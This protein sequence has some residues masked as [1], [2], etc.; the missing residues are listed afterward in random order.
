MSARAALAICLLALALAAA[1]FTGTAAAKV[2]IYSFET[3]V[4]STQA[5]AHA[6][7]AVRFEIG[8]RFT[9]PPVPCEC[10]SV[11]EI[12]A[13]L[14]PGLIAAPRNVPSCTA[15]EFARLKC[16]SDSQVGVSVIRLLGPLGQG[17]QYWFQP[18]Y[19]M[20]PRPG[21]LALQGT[22]TPFV[23]LPVIFTS[24][25]ARTE[26]DY[27][28]EVK[29]Y[30]IPDAATP[31]EVT[32]I[33]WGVPADDRHDV[34]RWPQTAVSTFAY[35]AGCDPE[36]GS[37]LPQLLA[38]EFPD[39]CAV[40][41]TENEED[42][43]P[44]VPLAASTPEVPF[45]A[46]PTACGGPLPVALETVAYD[47]ETDF[48]ETT[49]PAITGCDQLGFD[50]SL[51]AKPTTTAAD[52][53]SG[54]D[55]DLTVPQTLSPSTPSPSAIRAVTVELPEGFT[56]N[57]NAAE[58]K[59]SCTDQQ[60]RFGSRSPAQCPEFAKVGTLGVTSASFPAVLPGAIYLGEP[61]PG[62]RYRL[63][64]VFD[65]FSLHVKLPGVATPDPRTGRLRATFDNL[66]Q[67]NFQL[68]DMHFF[69]AERG[70][71]A[72]PEQCGRYA[73]ESEFV[74]W[75]SPDL[76]NQTST[77]FFEIDSGPEGSP[78]PPPQR[79]FRPQLTAGVTDNTGGHHTDFVFDLTRRDGDQN[80]S[81]IDVST[82]PGFTAILAGIPYCPDAALVSLAEASYQGTGELA[83]PACPASQVGTASAS[84]GTGSRPVSLP[85]RVYLAGPYKG[86]PLS[87]AVVT[88][89]VSG[90]YDL[91]NVVVRA[92]VSVDPLTGQVSVAS[93]PI[94]AL[95]EGIPLRL[96][97]VLVKLDRPNF[98]LNPTN[99]ASSSVAAAVFGD[100]GARSDLS[101]H[102]QVANCGS[103]DYG[104]ELRI[105]LTGGLNRRGHPA[106]K[107]VF[108]A[109]PNEAN[110]RKVTV[111][112]PPGELLDNAHIGAVCTRV[113]F[114]AK[115]CP[116]SSRLGRAEV[117]TPLLDQPLRG[118][119]YLRSGSNNL[120]DIAV[121]LKGQVDFEL[122]GRVDTAKNGSLRTHFETAPDVPVTQLVLSL[123]GGSK[124]LLINSE[125]L[126]KK[127]KSAKT[128]MVGHNG[129]VVKTATKLK[130]ACGKSR[131][132]RH[133]RSAGQAR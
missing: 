13:N 72:T 56:I 45:T 34:L 32:Q 88:P 117:T 85:G 50:P 28:L 90:P 3:Q 52:S 101:N 19:N 24:F 1:A 55:I 82:P 83:A 99:C 58:G 71:L 54:L 48:A 127:P 21:Q 25:E 131:K 18:I 120:P 11:K 2:P 9:E 106:I 105:S 4:A 67:F 36:L 112:L 69:G 17:G 113:A 63:L 41:L 126:C 76:P 91:G 20:E 35:T 74:P 81:A 16:P 47:L 80:L 128:T 49:F 70:L 68:F 75:A 84:A 110:T 22:F 97:R 62:N 43:G 57:P 65:G 37:P 60:A 100:Q 51:A 109:N 8:N 103:L 59:L 116:N 86:A 89:A 115:S 123:A 7:L 73:V 38:S 133:N 119:V 40:Q 87:L 64:L 92:A 39:V 42:S 79:P 122:L 78:C 61:L 132:K 14:P 53:P 121:D 31:N 107:A 33:F 114:A 98:V 102:F 30:G 66:P 15:S 77:Q 93:D 27:G 44:L 23:S 46:N 6:D 129:A 26:G 125:S 130:I 96:R 5:G 95:V 118:S 104:P 94:P 10:N 12:F 108:T 111:A 29:T 124:G